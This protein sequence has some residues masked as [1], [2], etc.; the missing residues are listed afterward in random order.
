MAVRYWALATED[1]LSEAV[2]RRL[3]A[4][5]PETIEVFPV[6]QHGGRGYLRAKMKSWTQMSQRQG[7]L[8]LTD[9]DR[10][11]CPLALLGDWLKDQTM[12]PSLLLRIA[13]RTVESWALSD[14]A[15]MRR[16][17]G[18]RVALP[19]RPDELPNPKQ[20]LLKL[21]ERAP[22]EVR[23]DLVKQQG[24]MASQGLGY[25]ARLSEWIR[26]AWSPSRA[27]EISPSLRRARERLR[28]RDAQLAFRS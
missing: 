10:L 16:L 13:V 7:V 19:P 15:A 5:L 1:A 23:L 14:H 28:E 12:P 17:V 22:R 18:P 25:N 20:H 6:L 9:L 8:I 2:G 4:E 11:E 26:S 24:A 21:A 3:L 27:A